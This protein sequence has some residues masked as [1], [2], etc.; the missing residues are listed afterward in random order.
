ML[1]N[2]EHPSWES[3]LQTLRAKRGG[4]EWKSRYV[5]GRKDLN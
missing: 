5:A 3:G 1:L 4:D 2:L